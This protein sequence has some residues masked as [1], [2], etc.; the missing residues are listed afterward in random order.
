MVSRG[1]DG[2]LTVTEGGPRRLWDI[3]DECHALFLDQGEP[4]HA[5]YGMTITRDRRQWLWLDCS[6]S[7]HSWE[8]TGR[9][10]PRGRGVLS[11]SAGGR[12]G[13]CDNL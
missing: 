13:T 12:D 2:Q 11:P 1:E 9:G 10:R 7:G 6:D 8:L 4:T 3:V 5:R